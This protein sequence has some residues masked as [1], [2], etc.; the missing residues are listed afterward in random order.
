MPLFPR[1][2]RPKTD[3][4]A[5][6]SNFATSYAP[7][8]WNSLTPVF[9]TTLV[10]YIPMSGTPLQITGIWKETRE[11]E[12]VSPGWV[13]TF[14]VQDSDIPGGPQEGDSLEE[15]SRGAFMVEHIN[16]YPVGYSQLVLRRTP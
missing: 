7:R 5:G 16:A 9:G 12:A 2:A 15:P 4:A 1:T 3:G 14:E 11:T 8:L 13:S 6:L 10:N